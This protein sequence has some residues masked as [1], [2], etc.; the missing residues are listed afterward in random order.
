MKNLESR[1]RLGSALVLAAF[2]LLQLLLGLSIPF[3]IAVH[4]I[5]ATM[6][7]PKTPLLTA[8]GDSIDIGSKRKPGGRAAT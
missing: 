5:V 3:L 8:V 1:L 7:P 4:A 6:G 2:V